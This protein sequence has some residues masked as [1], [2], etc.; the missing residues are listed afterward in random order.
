MRTHEIA[1]AA[2]F[3]LLAGCG[4]SA[5]QQAAQQAAQGAQQAAQ[6][7]QQAAQGAQQAGQAA[8]QGAQSFAQGMAQMAQGLKAAQTGPDGK[9]ITS[10]DFEKLVD[11]LPSP[12]GWDRAKPEGRQTSAPIATSVAE[13]RYTKGTSHADVTITDSALSQ[14]FMMP[15]TMMLS[16]N[17][18][19]RSTSGYKKSTTYG[20]QPG[21]ED[22]N[23]D[24]KH[25]E[26]TIVVNKRFIV[27]V[28]GDGLD[29]MDG[30]KEVANGI[31]LTKLAALQ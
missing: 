9:P 22:W 7:A 13:A 25:G 16:M 10:V 4:Q 21:V 12:A 14:M 3:V 8:Q 5:S 31:D 15:F 17:Y 20:T 30:L 24:S 2:A 6:G 11:L 19:E 27:Q 18:S 28:K 1:I 26:I 29:S 23:S